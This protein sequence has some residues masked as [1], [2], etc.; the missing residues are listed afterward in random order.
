MG[1]P[2]IYGRIILK[3]IFKKWDGGHGLD[4]KLNLPYTVANNKF[5]YICSTVKE[6]KHS[7]GQNPSVH[8]IPSHKGCINQFAIYDH[9]LQ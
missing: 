1:D 2:G 3:W 5:D 8:F 7:N 9:I 6:V 4:T